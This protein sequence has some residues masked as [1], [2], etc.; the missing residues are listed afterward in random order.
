MSAA[1][2]ALAAQSQVPMFSECVVGYRAW[3]VDAQGRLCPL[4]AG[5]WRWLPGVNTAR[6]ACPVHDS[7]EF[8]WRWLDGRRVL[9]PTPAHAA[10]DDECACGLYSWSRPNKAWHER[11]VWSGRH[12]V[13]G[14]VAS[15]GRLRVHH[16]GFR[17]EHACVVTLAYHEATP[18]EALPAL[19]RIAAAYRVELVTLNELEEAASRHGTPL[20][21]S[22]MPAA[23]PAA[24]EEPRQVQRPAAP[25]SPAPTLR[26][27]SLDRHSAADERPLSHPHEGSA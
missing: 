8:E 17:A 3:R 16:S 7:L 11:P 19:E 2:D 21:E 5:K 12:R 1:D 15:W 27:D 24:P 26:D 6:C 18:P 22:L 20:P 10:P 14:A 4:G 9:E 13:V 25:T 23:S